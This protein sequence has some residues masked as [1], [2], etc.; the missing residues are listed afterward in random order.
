MTARRKVITP[1]LSDYFHFEKSTASINNNFYFNTQVFN[2]FTF[3]VGLIVLSLVLGFF[4]ASYWPVCGSTILLTLYLYKKTSKLCHGVSIVRHIPTFSKEKT[5]ITVIY[6]VSNETGFKLNALSFQDEF[7]GVQDGVFTVISL[8]SIGAQ[9][10]VTIKHKI[11]LNAGMGIKEFKPIKLSIRDELGIFDFK[12]EFL[13]TQ[14]IEVFPFLEETPNLKNSISPD[15]IEYGVYELS[16]RGDT[17]L[18]MGTREYRRGDPVKHINW[19]LTKKSDKV[20]V[21]EYEK[22]TNTFVTLLLELD[23][24]SQSG[25]GEISTWEMTKDLALSICNNEIN[26]SNSIQVI[27]NNLFIPFGTGKNQMAMFEKHF[28]LHELQNSENT[29]HMRHLS[30][31][32]TRGQVY[33]I[34]PI[35]LSQQSLEMLEQLK[36]LKDLGHRVIVFTIN[37]LKEMASDSIGKT[38]LNLLEMNR[39]LEENLER[40]KTELK[41]HG[42]PIISL[43][44]SKVASL[45]SQI[46]ENG[47]ELLE[48]K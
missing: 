10:Q 48:V 27:S 31:L 40:V 1:K 13:G 12:V 18:F 11:F 43:S 44:A 29:D 9:T 38:K 25:S 2:G 4:N 22:S 5:E 34:C 26:R 14:E 45:S 46:V 39:H 7:D 20:I 21:N 35:F 6:K 30:H 17:N 16:K 15:S 3:L 28:T 41:R 42:I 32:P 8:K 47:K 19:K 23:L 37:P 33:F 24:K 36:K